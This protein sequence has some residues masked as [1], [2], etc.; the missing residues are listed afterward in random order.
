M[1]K[2]NN[3]IFSIKDNVLV[4]LADSNYIDQAKQLFSSV[5]LNA[6]WDG[7][8]L[9][10]AHNIPEEKLTWFRDKGIYVY[11]CRPLESGNDRNCGNHAP[12]ILS[13]FYIFDVYFKKWKKVVYLDADIIVVGSFVELNSF[14]S[15]YARP[16]YGGKLLRDQI[17]HRLDSHDLVALKRSLEDRYD[18][19]STSFNAGV[20]VMNTDIIQADSFRKICVL[21]KEYGSLSLF[22]DQ[23]IT[24]LFVYG[25]WKPLPNRFNCYMPICSRSKS[26]FKD[27]LDVIIFHFIGVKKVWQVKNPLLSVWKSNLER[28]KDI[29]FRCVLPAR[30]ERSKE[31]ILRSEKN[32]LTREMALERKITFGGSKYFLE[33]DE[34]YAKNMMK[35]FRHLFL[36][37]L[38]SRYFRE[39]IKY[40][41]Y[42]FVSYIPLGL[43]MRIKEIIVRSKVA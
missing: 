40:T 30:Q 7:D 13:K 32:I 1:T 9:L 43:K 6:G 29:D 21:W 18:I 42:F 3:I 2:K 14:S 5:Y 19:N 8:Y 25:K 23:L 41:P 11:E 33:L 10:L 26:F 24:N 37:I 36:Q 4:T 16:D 17:I 22:G 38:R 31:M 28:A 39:Y 27:N 34:Y 12:T 20:L 35:E 15:F